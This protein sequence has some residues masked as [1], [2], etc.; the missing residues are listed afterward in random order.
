MEE[1]NVS[2]NK[3]LIMIIIVLAVLLIA[4][5]TYIVMNNKDNK[6]DTV[7]KEGDKEGENPNENQNSNL[8][9][10]H[11]IGTACPNPTKDAKCNLS[12]K[13]NGVDKSLTL[14]TNS[15]NEPYA[16]EIIYH[17]NEALLDGKK[18]IKS[19]ASTLYGTAYKI[20]KITSIKDFLIVDY[21][22]RL[23]E[24]GIETH[25]ISENGDVLF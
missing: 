20:A 3:V 8:V 17:Y 16:S 22:F 2:N 11:N 9:M 15:Y 7:E 12:I 10:V 6:T 4:A 18:I 19:G 24:G 5:G 23:D 13:I 25:V 21:N 14:I 1:K